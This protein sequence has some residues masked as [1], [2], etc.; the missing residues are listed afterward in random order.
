[1][2][3]REAMDCRLLEVGSGCKNGQVSTRNPHKEKVEWMAASG[4]YITSGS[5]EEK[6]SVGKSISQPSPLLNYAFDKKKHICLLKVTTGH[7]KRVIITYI[8][9]TS[10]DS[11]LAMPN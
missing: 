6:P 8:K 5:S 7:M 10:F 2:H 11:L 1:M 3:R 9:V 4:A